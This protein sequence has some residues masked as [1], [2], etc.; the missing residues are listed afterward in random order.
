V[1][2]GFSILI[3]PGDSSAEERKIDSF[4][5]PHTSN[6]AGR[7]EIGQLPRAGQ[8]DGGGGGPFSWTLKR[9]LCCRGGGEEPMALSVNATHRSR[10]HKGKNCAG[11]TTI[12]AGNREPKT[13]IFFVPIR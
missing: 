2:Q 1:A 4:V 10:L 8:G 6:R 9:K 12:E 3:V 13:I 7:W 11:F 5:V